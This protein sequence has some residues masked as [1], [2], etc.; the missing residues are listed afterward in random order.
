MP[1][2]SGKGGRE[3]AQFRQRSSIW[4]GI[5][6]ECTPYPL[7]IIW[8]PKAKL[9]TPKESDDLYIGLLELQSH[10]LIHDTP[11]QSGCQWPEGKDRAEHMGT[12]TI[13]W[14]DLRKVRG[15]SCGESLRQTHARAV[16]KSQRE[17]H[18]S[19]GMKRWTRGSSPFIEER[20]DSWAVLH[21][22]HKE[23]DQENDTCPSHGFQN[24]ILFTLSSNTKQ[25]YHIFLNTQHL[26]V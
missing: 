15:W 24:R 8:R 6:K 16:T 17:S 19:L 1:S 20:K 9:F 13:G 4:H 3:K 14:F 18:A 25:G 7:G 5:M 22:K 26:M 23:K 2:C 21:N 12:L 11:L 10:S